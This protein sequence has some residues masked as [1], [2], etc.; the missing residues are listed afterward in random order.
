MAHARTDA[1][2]TGKRSDTT[3]RRDTRGRSRTVATG[4]I[5]GIIANPASGRDVRR[6]V[7]HGGATT[8][9][10]KLNR[11]QRILAGLA[12]TGVDRVISMSDRGGI[13]SGIRR[14]AGRSLSR[15]W[16]S[17]DFVDQPITHTAADTTAATQAMVD[18]GVGA[19]VV[20]GGDGTM[21][22][23]AASSLDIPILPI[24]TGTNNAFPQPIE[25][26]VAG[27]AAGLVA[28]DDG[29][30]EAGTYRAKLLRVRCGERVESA[31]VDVAITG[32]NGVGSG[33]VW[34]P[35][36]ITEL[37]LCFAETGAIGLSSIGG[38][39]VPT[40]RR[41]S[42][43]LHLR[44]GEPSAMVVRPPI[45]PGLLIPVGVRSST[46]LRAEES[47]VVEASSGVV[48]VDGERM[49]R[50][51]P[52]SRPTITLHL[53]GPVVVDASATLDHAARHR[54]L[55]TTTA[56]TSPGPAHPP[57]SPSITD[58]P[59]T[60]PKGRH[61]AI[62]EPT[63]AVRRDGPHPAVRIAHPAGVPR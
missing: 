59:I 35:T 8:T 6:L 39:I 40:S 62:T 43:G 46:P 38:H 1:A 24:S 34:D 49:L 29:A 42:T 4:T 14:L 21:R 37:F 11:L 27:L 9:H 47:V 57:P 53:G 41:A 22:I 12:A 55:A 5:V 25:P 26:T 44:L 23:V 10:D 20:L 63:G 51:G 54:L 28:T 56:A 18:A 2:P 52:D 19:I 50:F 61:R 17:I 3:S 33:A 13:A 31:L 15:D 45:G 7:A 60:N 30:R 32:A 16:P 58:N 36:S 48:A